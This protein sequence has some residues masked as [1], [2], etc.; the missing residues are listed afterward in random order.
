[1]KF[2]QLPNSANVGAYMEPEYVYLTAHAA[3]TEGTLYSL[4]ISTGGGSANGNVTTSA[5][6]PDAAVEGTIWVV[7]AES[8]AS[9]ARCK[10][11]TEGYVKLLA[12]TGDLA[13]DGQGASSGSSGTT[14]Q[15]VTGDV[16]IA[17]CP[18]AISSGALG[19]VMFKGDGWYTAHAIA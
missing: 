17:L 15:A 2:S 6:A 9:G 18:N 10:F 12:G 3:I 5:A 7:A 4:D 14:I 19:Y 8:A 16:I 1:M 13:V 11:Y